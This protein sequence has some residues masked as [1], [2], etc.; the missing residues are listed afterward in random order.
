MRRVEPYG[1]TKIS[2][3]GIE[4]QRV[5][6]ILD[7]TDPH[8]AWQRLGHGYRVDVSIQVWEAKDVLRLPIGAMFRQRNQWAVYRVDAEG[9]VN[10]Q[11]VEIGHINNL[12]A[13]VTSGLSEN[14]VVILHPSDRIEKGMRVMPRDRDEA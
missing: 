5:N 3:L 7:F 1:F 4:E 10:L 6:V 12:E 13:E 8:A 14:M 11:P 2:A 9:I